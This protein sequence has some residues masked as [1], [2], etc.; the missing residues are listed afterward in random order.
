MANAT[1]TK[2]RGIFNRFLDFI[3]K[4]GNKLPDP[5][6]LFVYITAAILIASAIFGFMGTTATHPGTGE[7]ITVVNLLN[8]DGLVRILTEMVTNFTSFPP[9]GLVLVVMLGVGLAESTGLITA[10]LKASILKAPQ[11][12]ILPV[13]VIVSI[14]GNAAADAAMVVLP[15]IVAMIFIE[16]GRHPIAGMAAAYASCAGGFAAN[17]I[18]SLS[19][20]LVYG[21]TEPAAHMIDPD[22]VGNPMINYYFL[23]VSALVLVPV[24]TFV[25]NRIVEPRL[26]KYEGAA[27]GVG[28]QV[29]A[30]EK[31]GLLWAGLSL[32]I[33]GAIIALLTL[34]ENAILRNPEDGGLIVSPFMDSLIPIMMILFLVPALAY[35]KASGTLKDSKDLGDQLSKAMAGMGTYI[36]IAFIAGQMIAYFN[37]SNLGPVIAIKGAAALDSIGLTG[38]PLFIGFM[39]VATLINLLVAS[40]SAKWAILAP[41]FIPM[42][43]LLGYDPA[44]TQVAYRIG[45]SITNPITPM[46]AYF[47]IVLTFAKKYDPKMGIGTFMSSLL[48]YT[49]AFAIMWTILFSV[50]YLLGLPLGPGGGIYLDQ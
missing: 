18:L 32:V 43:M 11:K 47:A 4:Y 38:L 29:T 49:I 30:E 22:Y 3:E 1:E 8:A 20:P 17:L 26:G 34:P 28:E 42:F 31:K 35:G 33:T 10:L 5:I 46:L 44:V 24:A 48:P 36:V 37:W 16:L 45:D 25:T 50:W 41:V 12:I 39:I 9:L 15:P 13:I 7:K 27:E 14:C 19:D 21:F 6:M 23:V 40:Q 2:K